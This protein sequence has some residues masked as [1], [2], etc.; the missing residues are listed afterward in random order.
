MTGTTHV[1]HP[2]NSTAVVVCSALSGRRISGL[3]KTRGPGA[4]WTI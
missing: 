4:Y 3:D 2:L 1:Q